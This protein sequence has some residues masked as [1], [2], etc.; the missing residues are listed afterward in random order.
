MQTKGGIIKFVALDKFKKQI[1]IKQK[2]YKNYR[3][4]FINYIKGR[5]KLKPNLHDYLNGLITRARNGVRVDTGTMKR[6]V[7]YWHGEPQ[8][9][10]KP[11][12]L[13]VFGIFEPRDKYSGAPENP[14]Y[15]PNSFGSRGNHMYP[16]KR[17]REKQYAAKWIEPNYLGSM[18]Y[19]QVEREV[20]KIFKKVIQ[21]FN[22]NYLK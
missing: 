7:D 1:D 15:K 21:N 22:K 10:S 4:V 17:G 8:T 6:R 14:Y 12:Y 3:I 19:G 20:Q 9:W 13:I 2:K 16:I 11:W 18:A 5:I